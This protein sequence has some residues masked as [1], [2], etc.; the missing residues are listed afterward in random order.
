MQ[1]N[2]VIS[3]DMNDIRATS[4]VLTVF[5]SLLTL[6][7]AAF[8]LI[9]IFDIFHLLLRSTSPKTSPNEKQFAESEAPTSPVTPL[10]LSTRTLYAQ[11]LLLGI[12]SVAMIS[13]LIPS[14]IFSRTGSG[15]LVVQQ[16]TVTIPV[17][18]AI[19]V[20]YWDYGFFRCLAAAPW[21]SMAVSLPAT[22]ITWVAWRFS[23]LY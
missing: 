14:T 9:L 12:L 16:E 11:T 3:F 23:L 13:V 8:T 15:H 6:A 4:V 20:V 5:A 17:S 19:D 1:L 22:A 7:S 10:P 2:A 21:F 18:F